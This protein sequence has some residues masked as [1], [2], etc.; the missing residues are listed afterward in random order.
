MIIPEHLQ[1]WLGQCLS[2]SLEINDHKLVYE[3]VQAH[4]DDMAVRDAMHEGDLSET[5][6]KNCIKE[7]RL[8]VLRVYPATPVG[9]YAFY[10]LT[11]PSVISKL[12][13]FYN[14]EIK[15]G[16]LWRTVHST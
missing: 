15:D 10:G 8:V 16:C 4:L 5:E 9:H 1:G 7:N 3:T 14:E 13:K 11:I 2:W 12:E 6:R